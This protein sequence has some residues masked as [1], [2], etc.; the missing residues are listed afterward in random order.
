MKIKKLIRKAEAF[1]NSEERDRQEKTKYLKELLK[2]LRQR[3]KKLRARLEDETGEEGRI[4]LE[5]KLALVHAQRKKGV[6]LLAELQEQ[7]KED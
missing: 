1:L 7:S 4:K 5:K 3:E 6:L 2:K